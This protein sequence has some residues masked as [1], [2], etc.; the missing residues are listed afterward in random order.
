VSK[1]FDIKQGSSMHFNGNVMESTLDIDA[2]HIV[3]TSLASL[4]SSADSSAVS[5]RRPVECGIN[6]SGK[7]SNP[8][9]DFSIKVPDLDPNTNMAVESALGTKDKVQKQFVAL[10]L[11][12]TFLPED[13]SGV[14]NGTN[15]IASNVGEIVSS[16]LNN[17]LQKLDIPLDFGLGYQQDKVG[18]DIFDVAV[19]T[20]LFNNR[21]LVNGSVGNRKY[22]TSKSAQGD[23]VGDLDIEIK[24]DRSGEVRFKLFSHSADEFSSSL[25]F[26]QRNGL[27][28]SYQKEFDRTIDFLRQLFMSRQR[29]AAEMVNEMTRKREMTTIEVT[30]DDK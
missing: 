15:M 2:I 6:I 3:K 4:V 5:T 23:V 20:Q 9:V 30:R 21:V 10:L 29:R 14:V 25:D 26:S 19:S 1:E 17:I 11:F 13:G 7:I 16:Q 28:F 8:D 24:L 22:S 27:G 12:G 18:T